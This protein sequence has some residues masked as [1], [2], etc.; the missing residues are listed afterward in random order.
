VSPPPAR[1]VV[2]VVALS[3]AAGCSVLLDWNLSGPAGDAGG[4]D[5]GVAVEGSSVGEGGNPLTHCSSS[6]QCVTAPPAGWTG[7]VALYVGAT[8]SGSAPAC[9]SGFAATPAFDGQGGTLSAPPATCTACSCGVPTGTI[10]CSDPV[11][12]FFLDD[13]CNSPYGKALTVSGSCAPTP[14]GALGTI[15]SAP[16]PTGG[17]C[18]ASGG[19]PTTSAP[20]WEQLARACAPSTPAGQADCDAGLVCAP[21]PASPFAPQGCVLQPG[22]ATSCPPQYPSGPRVFYTGVDDSR[23]CSTC[24]CAGPSGGSCTITN[25]AI[26]ACISSGTWSAPGACS[27]ITGPE[28]VRLHSGATPTLVDPGTCTLTDGGAPSG[29]ATGNGATTFCCA[30]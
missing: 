17:A 2:A 7:P 12:S 30:P 25:P 26:E 4:V 19:V 10:T 22:E 11:M 29:T 14:I 20:T 16:A 3:G 15:V 28:P 21:A 6:M 13:T 23:G 8:A 24:Q 9:G 1:W 5:G 18:G 27:S